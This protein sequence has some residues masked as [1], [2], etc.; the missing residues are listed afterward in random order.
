MTKKLTIGVD[1]DDCLMNLLSEW[2]YELNQKSG[3]SLLPIDI[4]KWGIGEF[5]P[6]LEQ[7]E[8][9]SVL[10]NDAL[11]NRLKP[12]D[13]AVDFIN[14]LLCDGHRIKIITSSHY[15][16]MESKMNRFFE[17]FP[18]LS[19]GQVTVTME[20]KDIVCD[21]LIDDNP[22]NLIGGKYYKILINKPHNF[23]FNEKQHNVYRA[24]DLA[25]AY[26]ILKSL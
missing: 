6:V 3:L 13:G 8:I 21:V 19:W 17:V 26:Q 20:K 1:I 7:R 15:R 23:S 5:Y 24:Y 10:N 12:C 16:N 11:W 2:C 9:F 4:T 22:E 25:E 14:K 18:M